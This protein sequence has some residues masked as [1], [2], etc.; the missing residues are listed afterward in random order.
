MLEVGSLGKVEAQQA[1]RVLVGPPLPGC[2]GIGKIDRESGFALQILESAK[3]L[4]IVQGQCLAKS[5]R[6]GL[7]N[8]DSCR[9][10]RVGLA[11]RQ[12]RGHEIPTLALNMSG[13]SATAFAANN[14]VAFPV[15]EPAA[16]SDLARTLFDADATGDK[17]A[18][19]AVTLL[20]P[21][22]PSSAAQMAVKTPTLPRVQSDPA[23]DGLMADP[24]PIVM[25]M[26]CPNAI[27]YDFGRPVRT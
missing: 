7:I 10:E 18:A 16:I 11:I 4:A 9:V 20:P 23:A 14:Q 27:S 8:R 6:Q 21:A 1:V 26:V 15:A 2:V 24:H 17:A 12:E 25:W 19:R 13:N 3:L 22:I 5:L